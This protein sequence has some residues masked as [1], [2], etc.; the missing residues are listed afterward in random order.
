MCSVTQEKENWLHLKSVWALP[1]DGCYP[2]CTPSLGEP[3]GMESHWDHRLEG[4]PAPLWLLRALVGAGCCCC[5]PLKGPQVAQ[6][7]RSVLVGL[8]GGSALLSV[9][10]HGA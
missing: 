6:T 4:L 8:W 2:C 5:W 7:T 9:S 10:H 3:W 1:G